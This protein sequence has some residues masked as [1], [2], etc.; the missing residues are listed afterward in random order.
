M[1][2]GDFIKECIEKRNKAGSK[3]L[4][5]LF[6]KEISNSTYG[7]TAQGLRMKRVYDIRD[8]ETKPLPPSRITNPCY[9]SYITSFVRGLLGEIINTIPDDKVVFSCTTDGFL[10]N[11]PEGKID[12]LTQGPL[13]QVYSQARLDLVGNPRIVEI[14]HKI[15]RPLGWKT[16]GQATLKQITG[17]EDDPMGTVLAKGGIFTKPEFESTSDQNDEIVRMFFNREPD[18]LIRVES[19]VGMRDIIE[20]DADLVQREISK[21]LNME[22]DWKRCSVT[23][24]MSN[25]YKHIFFQTK[26]WKNHSQ[27]DRVREAWDK[28]TKDDP[29]VIKS[30]DDFDGFASYLE[31]QSY[32]E[33]HPGTNI[34][35]KNPDLRRLRQTLCSAW[36]HSQAGLSWE[37]LPLSHQKFAEFLTSYGLPCKKTDVENGKKKPFEPHMCPP[38]EIVMSILNRL[39]RSIPSLDIEM[40]I[41]KDT[42]DDAIKLK[43]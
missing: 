9:A 10:T 13:A 43:G 29:K 5:G 21:R 18:Q 26:P 35:R 31:F 41:Y 12:A 11:F 27:F 3:T 4:E 20:H 40:I 22:F 30:L 17:M 15:E 16:R 33:N 38:T 28:Y 1:I 19:M 36:K 23:P 25:E 42:S 8:R 7:K 37:D 14:K 39:K 34:A 32:R 2:F 6:W 24:Q